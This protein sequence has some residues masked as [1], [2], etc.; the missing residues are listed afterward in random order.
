MRL[1][2]TIP[3]LLLATTQ[4]G[5]SDCGSVIRDAGFDLWCGDDLCSW[6]VLRG[7]ARRATT[8]HD[9]DAGVE[10][11][12]DDAAIAQLSPVEHT[13]GTCLRFEL[14]ADVSV[15]AEARL[16]IDV[17]GDGTIEL[18]ERLPTSS[19]QPLA[20]K[21]RI[22]APFSGVRFELSKRGPG[23][24][25]FAQI[26]A[27]TA[28]DCDGL[29]ELDGGPAPVGARCLVDG[30]CDS[31]LCRLVPEPAALFGAA[32]RC[33]ACDPELAAAACAAGEVCGRGRPRSPILG[34]P[35][36]C[37]AP[38]G[39]PLGAQC[40][41]DDECASGVCAE[42]TCSTC[43][44]SCASGETCGP[45]WPY[46]PRVCAP[47]GGLRLAGEPCAT[48]ADCASGRCAGDERRACDD[49]RPCVT[50][51]NCPVDDGLIP[52]ACTTVGVQGG[53]CE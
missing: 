17:Y 37:V 13:D 45:A 19:W 50:D 9:G 36:E 34:V 42:G 23:T 12:G 44:T 52:G 5:A 33:T 2:F 20:Y 40:L 39:D 30:D 1:R 21:I 28:T 4:L 18:D 7:E 22:K 10:L 41:A 27:F 51:A 6:K 31:G 47:G 26:G 25:V 16:G 46:G 24:A 15:D 14:V 32:Q 43:R 49:G 38:A 35:I 11:I 8:W 29:S 53:S 48:A 3:L